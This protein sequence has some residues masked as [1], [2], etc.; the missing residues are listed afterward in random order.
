[1][2]FRICEPSED[3]YQPIRLRIGTFW[4]FKD[5]KIFHADNEG[6]DSNAW[7]RWAHMSEGTLFHVGAEFLVLTCCPPGGSQS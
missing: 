2:Y 6:S 5:A 1:M 3:S 7:M 4:I